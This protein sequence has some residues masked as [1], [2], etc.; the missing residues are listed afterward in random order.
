MSYRTEIPTY[1]ID[2]PSEA[3]DLV[4]A[5]R[6]HPDYSTPQ[7]WNRPNIHETP[8]VDYRWSYGDMKPATR[9]TASHVVIRVA[10]YSDYSGSD[11]EASNYR[12]LLRDFPDRFV[13]LYGDY[14]T[15]ALML[16]VS[17]LDE[18]VLEAIAGLADYPLYD[19]EDSSALVMEWT[20]SAIGDYLRADMEHDLDRAGRLA[21][22]E[23]LRATDDDELAGFVWDYYSGASDYPHAEA[24]G[25]VVFP[26]S[27]AL[28]EH[29]VTAILDAWASAIGRPADGQTTLALDV[30]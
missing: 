18:A 17:C 2:L 22:A 1:P 28:R 9:K 24:V 21:E 30:H 12:S 10:S 15:Q 6:W 20:E 3:V 4:I 8:S 16:P 29:V 25:S 11:V 26:E 19:E 5:E 23:A 14:G 13:E 27:D 7:W